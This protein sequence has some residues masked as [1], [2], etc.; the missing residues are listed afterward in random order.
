MYNHRKDNLDA[1]GWR[2][3]FFFANGVKLTADASWSRAKR[4]ELNLE[5]NTQL[6]PSPQLDSVTLAFASNGFS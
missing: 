5:N 4:D 3:E 1:A 2:N 6:M